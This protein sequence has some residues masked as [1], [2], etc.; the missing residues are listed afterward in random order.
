[1]ADEARQTRLTLTGQQAEVVGY[2]PEGDLLV[3]GLPGSGKT[4]T[5]VA[6]AARLASMPLLNPE[7]G[8]PLVRVFSFNQM[9]MEWIR[10]LANQL[11]ETPPEVTTFDSW[12]YRSLRALG[13]TVPDSYDDYAS[14][15]IAAIKAKGGMPRAY[16]AHHVLV[17]EAQDLTSE[18][19]RVVKSSALTSFT[20]AAD[21]A[22]NIYRTGF[23]WKSV[24]INVQGRPGP[25][26]QGCGEPSRSRALPQSL[27]KHDPDLAAED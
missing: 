4:L 20:V 2:R 8:V 5:I 18:E 3:K 1:M 27:A 22:Q 23:T 15:L 19:L 17:D 9:L 11:D 13:T 24:G 14:A 10:F 12:A 6:R 25:S 26:R 7:A 21:K 16:L